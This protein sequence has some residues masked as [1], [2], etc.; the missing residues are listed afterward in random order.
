MFGNGHL[1]GGCKMSNRIPGSSNTDA[2]VWGL[3]LTPNPSV[4][5]KEQ[6]DRMEEVVVQ[7]TRICLICRLMTSEHKCFWLVWTVVYK[8][9]IK[10]WHDSEKRGRVKFKYNDNAAHYQTVCGG[11]QSFACLWWHEVGLNVGIAGFRKSP[12][13]MNRQRFIYH[14]STFAPLY[15]PYAK[16]YDSNFVYS[17]ISTARCN[18]FPWLSCS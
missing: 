6:S 3:R 10:T 8:S 14:K 11:R 12:I 1:W 16:F 13:E 2:L 15:C 4:W 5:Q 18:E 9:G 7:Q 17:S